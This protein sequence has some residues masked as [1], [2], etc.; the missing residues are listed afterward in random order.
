MARAGRKSPRVLS[1]PQ[2]ISP[3]GEAQGPPRNV[4][5]SGSPGRKGCGGATSATL[6]S[7]VSNPTLCGCE[8]VPETRPVL[9]LPTLLPLMNTLEP[10][11]LLAGTWEA[12]FQPALVPWGVRRAGL[13]AVLRAQGPKRASS[14]PQL[15]TAHSLGAGAFPSAVPL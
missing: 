12:G 4:D 1:S 11:C 15:P 10:V 2:G 3:G 6:H 14:E 8:A 7:S 9:Y 13:A 5:H